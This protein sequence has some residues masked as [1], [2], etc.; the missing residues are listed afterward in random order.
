MVG[1]WG[2]SEEVGPVSA[3]PRSGEEAYTPSAA[4]QHTLELIDEEVKRV[5]AEC[6]DEAKRRLAGHRAQLDKLAQALLE[7][8]TLDEDDA[9]AVAG[10]ARSNG[11]NGVMPASAAPT[12]RVP[13]NA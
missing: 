2:M 13:E 10:I 6:A 4:S 12:V 8:E 3:L 11:D 5:I 9:Y 1:R 7:R